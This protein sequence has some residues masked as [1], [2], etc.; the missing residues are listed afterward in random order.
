MW[1]RCKALNGP[2][3]SMTDD[4]NSIACEAHQL[5]LS[6]HP[7]PTDANLARAS[8]LAAA[9][10]GRTVEPRDHFRAD[11]FLAIQKA[12]QAILAKT[13]AAEGEKLLLD[14]IRAAEEWVKAR[15]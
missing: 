6:A 5:P 8:E 1:S 9:Q 11:T 7:Q 13:G 4:E 10:H 2:I 12:R 3:S 14:A 15:T